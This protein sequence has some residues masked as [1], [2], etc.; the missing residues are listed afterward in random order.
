MEFAVRLLEVLLFLA[1]V[2]AVGGGLIWMAKLVE[3]AIVRLGR[4]SFK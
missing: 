2:P 1:L 3:K 4:R